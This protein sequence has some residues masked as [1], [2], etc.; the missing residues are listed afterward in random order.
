MNVF[1]DIINFNGWFC[2]YERLIFHV[3]PLTWVWFHQL[4]PSSLTPQPPAELL[5]WQRDTGLKVQRSP[6]ASL[7]AFLSDPRT[8]S[9]DSPW[10]YFRTAPTTKGIL[11]SLGGTCAS[12]LGSRSPNR[13][14][15]EIITGIRSARGLAKPV[16]APAVDLGEARISLN[17]FWSLEELVRIGCGRRLK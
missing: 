11:S 7:P 1:H 3:K 2:F 15:N 6:L 17:Y 8:L 16:E 9:R 5:R 14:A 12:V 13:S 10:S 4:L